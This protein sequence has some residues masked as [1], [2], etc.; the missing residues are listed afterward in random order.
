[1][2]FH[3]FNI[4]ISDYEQ[5]WGTQLSQLMPT[6]EQITRRSIYEFRWTLCC[7]CKHVFDLFVF[8]FFWVGFSSSSVVLFAD[9][10]ELGDFL[11]LIL[12]LR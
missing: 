1:M 11:S 5:F 3:G 2:G 10:N 7:S 6:E 4:G 8:V 9:D 12:Y